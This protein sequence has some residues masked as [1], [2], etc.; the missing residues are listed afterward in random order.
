[1]ASLYFTTD[2]QRFTYS[3]GALF[4]EDAF[5]VAFRVEDVPF[6]MLDAVLEDS[7]VATREFTQFV[8]L[9]KDFFHENLFLSRHKVGVSL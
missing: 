9:L 1:M 5:R 7:H 8:D 4:S 2:K 3:L 6:E